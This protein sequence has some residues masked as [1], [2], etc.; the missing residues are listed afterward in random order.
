MILIGVAKSNS[1]IGAGHM[2]GHGD[3]WEIREEHKTLLFQEQDIRAGGHN[4]PL[5]HPGK[6]SLFWHDT[7]TGLVVDGAAVM[8]FLSDLGNLKQG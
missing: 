3:V 2:S 7:V 1:P 6:D 8:T 4:S 5:E